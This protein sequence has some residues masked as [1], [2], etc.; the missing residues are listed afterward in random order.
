M[1]MG[2]FTRRERAESAPD[3]VTARLVTALEE[4]VRKLSERV[5]ELEGEEFKLTELRRQARNAVRSLERAAANAQDPPG[6][7]NGGR[8]V[9]HQPPPVID[10]PG[11]RRN[12]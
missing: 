5:D 6:R 3:A 7:T 2:L 4:T 10:S 12:Y 1:P 8:A 11:P 9:S